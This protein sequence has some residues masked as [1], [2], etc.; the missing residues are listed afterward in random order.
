[1]TKNSAVEE[2][3]SDLMTDLRDA[4]LTGAEKRIETESVNR[5]EANGGLNFTY[6]FSENTKGII[7]SGSTF[8]SSEE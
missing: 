8:K 7:P 4:F 5:A 6:A 3:A 1:M 2:K